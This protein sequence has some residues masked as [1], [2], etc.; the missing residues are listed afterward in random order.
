MRQLQLFNYFYYI[1]Y[2]NYTTKAASIQVWMRDPVNFPSL[3]IFK[4]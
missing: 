4:F 3:G 2:G 1:N